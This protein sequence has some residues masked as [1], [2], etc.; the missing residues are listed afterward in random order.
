MWQTEKIR[1]SG[2]ERRQLVPAPLYGTALLRYLKIVNPMVAEQVILTVVA[3]T[4]QADYVLL[5]SAP[6]DGKG[7]AVWDG[8]LAFQ[9]GD[10]LECYLAAKPTAE[11]HGFA[12]WDWQP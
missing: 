1:F 4:R 6:V 11:P 8:Y 10:A 12:T 3:R 7:I 2:V 5:D 9:V